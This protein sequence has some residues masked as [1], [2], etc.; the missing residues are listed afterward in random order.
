M[1]MCSVEY[2][3]VDVSKLMAVDMSMIV[4]IMMLKMC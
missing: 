1:P 4:L 2:E 3:E